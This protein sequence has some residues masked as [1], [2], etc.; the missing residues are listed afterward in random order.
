MEQVINFNDKKRMKGIQRLDR[1]WFPSR[2]NMMKMTRGEERWAVANGF[3][4][5][6][7]GALGRK[8]YLMK[9]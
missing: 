2:G 5:L 4:G 3:I 1:F 6:E 9:A 8:I 7:C